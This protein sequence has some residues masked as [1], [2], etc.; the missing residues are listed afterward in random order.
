M[1]IE[2]P[3]AAARGLDTAP[4]ELED[5]FARRSQAAQAD[6]CAD[7]QEP[8]AVV[9]GLGL[10]RGVRRGVAL[11]GRDQGPRPIRVAETNAAR[12]GCGKR[13]LGPSDSRWDLDRRRAG[14]DVATRP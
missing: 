2:P 10:E 12:P 8:G 3:A 11:A 4:L 6:C 5:D 1:T 9:H 7:R 13:R 14:P